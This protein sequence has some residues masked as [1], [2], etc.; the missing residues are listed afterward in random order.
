MD[1]ARLAGPPLLQHVLRARHHH[2]AVLL[3]LIELKSRLGQ[4]AL[5][6][7]GFSL[8]GQE[9]LSQ[10]V[11]EHSGSLV[12]DKVAMVPAEHLFDVVGMDEHVNGHRP[13]PYAN[14]IAV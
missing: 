9:A 8:A 4:A 3:D 6:A 2:L 14:N 5:A 13:D 10:E 11:R 12:L 7:P 1:F